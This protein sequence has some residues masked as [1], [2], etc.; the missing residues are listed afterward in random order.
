MTGEC[1]TLL[2]LNL[3]T[4]SLCAVSL[5][6]ASVHPVVEGLTEVPDGLIVDQRR[7]HVYW[8]NMGTS[9][10]G[11]DELIGQQFNTRNGSIERADLD[12]GNR[13]TIV[14][15]GSFTTGKQL[16]ADFDEG[17]LYWCD[18]EGTQVLRCNLDGSALEALVVTATTD[19]SER[20]QCVGIAV[21][22]E[23][24]L[25]YWSQKGAPKAGEGRI[26]RAPIDIPAGSTAVARNDIEL[27]WD[28]LPEPIDLHL[29]DA[30]HLLWTDRGAEPAG[31][32]LNRARVHP[33]VGTPEIVSRG[34]HEAIGLTRGG[35][36]TWYVGDL[37]G[38]IRMVDPDNRIDVE[39]IDLESPL[40]GL[41]VA[42]YSSSRIPGQG[43]IAT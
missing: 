15:P 14:P 21:D 31:N 23:R 40:T 24:R 18:R 28:N 6:G 19:H 42:S 1:E 34:Y 33:S 8:T 25:V 27:L 37:S 7:G 20:N 36:S 38:S 41:A 13:R 39:L 5:D 29:D 32:T 30:G 43:C 4:R 16:T 3:G 22:P 17:K 35:D 26:F 9:D 12:G 2:V 10:S 11:A